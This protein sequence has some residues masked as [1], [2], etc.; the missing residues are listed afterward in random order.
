M[1]YEETKVYSDG[2]HYIA[3]PK[4]TRPMKKRKIMSK[5]DIELKEKADKVFE[6]NKGKK[7]VEKKEELIA[8]EQEAEFQKLYKKWKQETDVEINEEIW[9]AIGFET[10]AQG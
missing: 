7:K 10:S 4:T 1:V 6:K 3:I 9:K 8:I 5:D 2:S